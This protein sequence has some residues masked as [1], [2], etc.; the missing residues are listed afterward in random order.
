MAKKAKADRHVITLECTECRERNYTTQKN[1]RNDPG[2]LELRK[3][4]PRCR[5]VRLH[6]ETR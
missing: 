5:C 6:R 1:R 4:C 2:R 3:F